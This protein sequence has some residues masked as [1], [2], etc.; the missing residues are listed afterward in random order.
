MKIAP[1]Y[2]ARRYVPQIVFFGSRDS[3]ALLGSRDNLAIHG[4][5]GSLAL[6]GSGDSL[7]LLLCDDFKGKPRV[8]GDFGANFELLCL[9][10]AFSDY[11]LSR[12]WKTESSL[13]LPRPHSC[14]KVY[15]GLLF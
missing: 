11:L 9:L 3:L 13:Y 4:S 8:R 5:E 2:P 7:V 14:G 10:D 12:R 6:L 1:F 15:F